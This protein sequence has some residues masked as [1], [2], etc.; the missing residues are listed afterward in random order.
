MSE[1]CR[2]IRITNQLT[3]MWKNMDLSGG[4]I[5]GSNTYVISDAKSSVS[6][7]TQPQPCIFCSHEPK[8]CLV[9]VLEILKVG[10][11]FIAE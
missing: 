7:D 6:P 11:N 2:N 9:E 5:V 3:D 10:F 8:Q 4:D 1:K